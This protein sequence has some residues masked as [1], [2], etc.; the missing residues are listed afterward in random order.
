MSR[1]APV[2][3]D[4]EENRVPSLLSCLICALLVCLVFPTGSQL[5]AAVVDVTA[6]VCLH[7]ATDRECAMKECPMRKHHTPETSGPILVCP[8][9][10]ELMVPSIGDIHEGGLRKEYE[11]D[12]I[13]LSVLL[14]KTVSA[15]SHVIQPSSPPP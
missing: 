13:E 9:A 11:I 2:V 3:F 4:C 6:P 10:Q 7:H 8:S 12:L 5:V 14:S 1:S 15:A